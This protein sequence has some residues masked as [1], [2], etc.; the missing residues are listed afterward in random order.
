[1]A[2]F[3]T[4]LFFGIFIGGSIVAMNRD[5]PNDIQCG[6]WNVFTASDS[7]HCSDY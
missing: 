5:I 1:M 2:K 7:G 4:G 6:R 3:I